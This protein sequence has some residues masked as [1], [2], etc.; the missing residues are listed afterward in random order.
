MSPASGV[1]FFTATDAYQAPTMVPIV[2][3]NPITKA[4]MMASLSLVSSPCPPAPPP[5]PLPTLLV[6]E[7][8]VV[9]VLAVELSGDVVAVEPAIGLS[10]AA[11]AAEDGVE[12]LEVEGEEEEEEEGGGRKRRRK[13]RCW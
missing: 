2:P 5:P 13:R 3:G 1:C 9:V 7:G 6:G 10:V 12:E 11:G 8:I 4:S